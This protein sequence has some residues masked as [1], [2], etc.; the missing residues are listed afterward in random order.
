MKQ[1]ERVND[2]RPTSLVKVVEKLQITLPI[3]KEEEVEILFCD[4]LVENIRKFEYKRIGATQETEVF[5]HLKTPA[6]FQKQENH[7]SKKVVSPLNMRESTKTQDQ[8]L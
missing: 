1:E 7:T 2:L 4:F 6:P 3:Q 8:L 5:I